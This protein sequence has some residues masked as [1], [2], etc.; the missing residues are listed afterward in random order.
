M[1]LSVMPVSPHV[2]HEIAKAQYHHRQSGILNHAQSVGHIFLS[3]ILSVKDLTNYLG[4][5]ISH[6]VAMKPKEMLGELKSAFFA[7]SVIILTLIFGSISIV[8]PSV[9]MKVLGD[10]K[11]NKSQLFTASYFDISAQFETKPL[12]NIKLGLFQKMEEQLRKSKTVTLYTHGISPEGLRL[13]RS[14]REDYEVTE[15]TFHA[16][17]YT[18]QNGEVTSEQIFTH[19]KA[20]VKAKHQHFSEE[21]ATKGALQLMANMLVSEPRLRVIGQESKIS[22]YP[23]VSDGTE[24]DRDHTV[25]SEAGYGIVELAYVENRAGEK[26]HNIGLKRGVTLVAIDV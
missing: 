10:S 15:S 3:T 7:L 19:L 25:E 24:T 17:T 1:A 23:R 14:A 8:L 6:L 4:R 5:A 12:D 18:A 9:S 22:K 20:H 21:D 16:V 26:T 13:G 11:L 2:R